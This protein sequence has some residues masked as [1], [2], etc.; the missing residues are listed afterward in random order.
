MNED[1]IEINKS[2]EFTERF[3]T[4]VV[5]SHTPEGFFVIEF[6]KPEIILVGDKG[7][8]IKGHKGTLVS[9][10]RII[11]TPVVCKKFLH[12]LEEQIKKFEEKF[13]EIKTD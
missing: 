8:K 10:V 13:G 3:E 1:E 5:V 2:K 12:I 6:L 4:A 9:D 11:L 7:G